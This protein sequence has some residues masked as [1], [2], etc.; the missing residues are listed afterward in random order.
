MSINVLFV[1]LGNICRSPTAHGVFQ[2]RVI[3]HQLTDFIRVDSAGTSG[4]HIGNA[5][6]PRSS[7]AAANRGF[8]LSAQRARQVTAS[9]F[10]KFHYVLAMD[11][12]NLSELELIKPTGYQGVLDLFLRFGQQSHV[13]QSIDE[14]NLEVPDPYYGEGDGFETVLNLVERASDGL[15]QYMIQQ[16][17][18]GR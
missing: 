12:A 10:E 9:D 2:Q 5:P 8:D 4:W 14:K 6:D 18:L 11:S 17:A 7:R 15:L 16:H 1:C 3:D 13:D